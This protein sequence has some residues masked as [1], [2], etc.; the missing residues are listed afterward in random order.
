ML[1]L[2]RHFTHN[3]LKEVLNQIPRHIFW[4]DRRGVYLGCNQLFASSF[5]LTP[6]HIIG[7]TDYDLP[8][9]KE[10]SEKFMEDDLE[11]I[12][13]G[14]AKINIEEKQTLPD[15]KFKYLLTSKVPLLDNRKKIIG[16]LG[17]YS[18][19]TEKKQLEQNLINSNKKLETTMQAMQ[20]A[21][22]QREETLAMYRQFVEDQEH[23]IRTPLGNVASCSEYLLSELRGTSSIDEELLLLLEGVSTSSR[24]ILDY[25]ESLLFELYQGQLSEETLFTRFDLPEIV[26]HAF[27]VNLVSARHKRIDYQYAFDR[28]IPNYLVGD[29]KRIYQCLVDLLSNAI[30]FTQQ[31]EVKLEVECI[32][33]SNTR[34]V[35]RFT[36]TDTGIGIPEDKQASILKAFVKAKPSNKGGERG[37]GLGLTRVSQYVADMEGELRFESVDGEG[38]CFRLVIPLKISLDQTVSR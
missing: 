2:N 19:I 32:E 17:I 12:Q 10:D 27:N 24:E 18:D 23:D 9:K 14:N 7:K 22:K 1:G 34:A 6:K 8:V 37:R 30:R 33:K 3:V 5:N 11:I 21:N 29:G 16:I 25:Q 4:K 35:I 31:G 20:N 15:G 38:S 13:T 36:I 26:Q 28:T